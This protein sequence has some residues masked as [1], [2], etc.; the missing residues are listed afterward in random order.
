MFKER[1]RELLEEKEKSNG[2]SAARCDVLRMIYEES[3]RKSK[4]HNLQKLLVKLKAKP[5]R[6]APGNYVK[7]KESLKRKVA[8]EK[9]QKEY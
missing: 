2:L 8:K 7:R 5:T 9:K 3:D 4:F 6:E 1:K